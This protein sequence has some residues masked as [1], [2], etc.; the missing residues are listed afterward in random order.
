M[1]ETEIMEIAVPHCVFLVRDEDDFVAMEPYRLQTVNSVMMGIPPM[2]TDV[3]SVNEKDP[4]VYS[5]RCLLLPTR[6]LSP[7]S[8]CSYHHG[9]ITP[10]IECDF[11]HFCLE[12][13]DQ[14]LSV[15]HESTIIFLWSLEVSPPND[16]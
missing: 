11:G 10:P 12:M 3:V 15:D 16:K 14:C 8:I 6:E 2:V 7:H 5:Y 9:S 4:S 1:M 13:D